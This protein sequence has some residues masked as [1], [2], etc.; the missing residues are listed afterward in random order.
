[1]R[2][3][4][5]DEI[6]DPRQG[7]RPALV[8]LDGGRG[9]AEAADG[10]CLVAVYGPGLGRR[11]TLERGELLIGRD[12]SCD[13]PVALDTVSRRHCLVS[14]EG[15]AAR[16]RDLGSTNGT[17]VNEAAV[18]GDRVVVLAPGDRL[19]AGGAIFRFLAGEDVET[20]Y[21][22][23]IYRTMI[24]DGLTLAHNR[25][26]LLEFLDRELAR[27]QRHRR[28]LSLVL[29][30][31]D[32]FQ[33]INDD[34][35]QL[36]GDAVL[37]DLATLVRARVRREDCFARWGGEAFAVALAE[38]DPAAAQMFAERMRQLVEAHEFRAQGERLPIT[39]SAG[40]ATAWPELRDAE[41]FVATADA[42]LVEA[43]RQGRN[44]V[45]AA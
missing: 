38:T 17:F 36:T 39:I 3:P 34:W 32:G 41:A 40:V 23:E 9:A 30:D 26:F 1:M 44:R 42:L 25:R 19:R 22:E 27:H 8:A 35:G 18:G 31:L 11:W 16:V 15:G 2:G 20:L 37:R 4:E 45:A 28:P 6:G 13:V 5:T 21:H 14:V 12:D 7:A 29:F 10:A 24:V 43:K 33:R